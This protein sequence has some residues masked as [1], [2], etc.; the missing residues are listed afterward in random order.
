MRR[1]RLS[2]YAA[3][4]FAAPLA[5]QQTLPLDE[6]LRRV[7]VLPLP[8]PLPPT[9]GTDLGG[10]AKIDPQLQRQIAA[11]NPVPE[12]GATRTVPLA[13][14]LI[15][16]R[17]Y[18][19]R[20]SDAAPVEIEIQRRNG[21]I[22][23]DF[24]NVIWAKIPSAAIPEIAALAQVD[25]VS[26]QP[27]DHVLQDSARDQISR[28]VA[29]GGDGVRAA[30][31][32]VLHQRGFTGKGVRIGILDRG[33]GGYARLVRDG[34]VKAAR[35]QRAFPA[36][37]G[38]FNQEVH[39]A[40]CAEV[41]FAGAPGADLYL[42]SFDGTQGELLAAARWLI[43][44][45]VTIINYSAGNVVSP[46]DGS[47]EVSAFLDATTRKSGVLWVAAAGNHAEQHWSGEVNAGS[48]DLPLDGQKGLAV[49]ALGSTLRI[50]VRW[51]DWGADPRAPSSTQDI[52]AYLYTVNDRGDLHQVDQSED[53]QNGG[54]SRPVEEID[55][56]A[57]R[58]GR[59]YF[60]VLRAKH[61]TRRVRIHVFLDPGGAGR[62]YPSV[63]QGS[64]LNPASARSALA[65]GAVDVVS[66]Q[67]ARYSSEGLT[68][69]GRLK[70]DVTAP[71][72]TVSF[73]Y[74]DATGRFAGTSASAPH[75]AAF[76][77]LL[78][79]MNPDLSPFELRTRVM[80]A[81]VP[82]GAQHPNLLYGYGEIDGLAVGPA[83]EWSTPNLLAME[84]SLAVPAEFGGRVSLR[85]LNDLRETA[86]AS[87]DGLQAWVTSGR[88]LYRIG[89]GIRLGV[90]ATEDCSCLLFLRDAHGE[91]TLVPVQKA[92]S[93]AL[94]RGEN[95]IFPDTQSEIMQVEG[96]PGIEELLLVCA[97]KPNALA[98]L[99]SRAKT[100]GIA[101]ASHAYRI[102][103]DEH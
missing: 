46:N 39:G 47:D 74:G 102:V 24:E 29:Q 10:P 65:V 75:V 42:A 83:R 28:T 71:S 43:A 15:P 80:A 37:Y 34:R 53:P 99:A 6:Y 82:K 59:Q 61:L 12:A 91:F 4:V 88:D 31:L 58:P 45:G 95:R 19:V 32:N 22:T 11:A 50:V 2:L 48:G 67:L 85:T 33:F 76:A 90:R 64:I 73:A 26:A 100:G 49:Q 38:V 13:A 25:S 27:V 20:L 1:W 8:E 16:V 5:A 30:H 35:D 94:R 51:S 55:L 21:E 23:A 3:L 14:N 18:T 68:D 40:A 36:A 103:A 79:E 17:I 57:T 98:S 89:D 70:P 96:E 62:I 101:V 66:N 92:G 69:D 52:N 93:V 72:N 56:S 63:A 7:S 9:R 78:K 86:N 77:A 54:A 81:V 87:R 97:E 44:Q 60:L 41:L 84:G